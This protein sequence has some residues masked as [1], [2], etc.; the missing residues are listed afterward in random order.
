VKEREAEGGP[1][2][3]RTTRPV[4]PRAELRSYGKKERCQRNRE[5]RE[6]REEVERT[7]SR[8]PPAP[9]PATPPA[10]PAV[11]TAFPFFPFPPFFLRGAALD[12]VGSSSRVSSAR[13]EKM[14]A[15]SPAGRE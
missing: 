8:I 1:K 7:K 12:L 10:P 2:G 3:R 9:P 11:A 5:E 15:R 6:E 13:R 14:V 4:L